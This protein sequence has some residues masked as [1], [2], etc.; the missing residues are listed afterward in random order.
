MIAQTILLIPTPE[1][2]DEELL[3]AALGYVIVFVALIA[4]YFVFASIPKLI[5]WRRS[6]LM[7]KSGKE[8]NDQC[9]AIPGDVLA[10]ISLAIYLSANE[11]HDQESQLMT[12]KKVS[13]NYS[14][15]SSK[16]Y[17]LNNSVQLRK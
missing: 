5:N 2:T 11:Y 9:D 12:I 6:Y 13:R 8:C 16:I 4:M 14:P 7:R 17:G 10:A 3:M 1:I 15:W